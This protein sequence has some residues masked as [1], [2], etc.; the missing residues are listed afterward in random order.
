M[1]RDE[2]VDHINDMGLEDEEI[3]LFDGMENA[4]LGIAERFEDHGH[5]YFAVYSYKKMVT[6]LRGRFGRGMSREDAIDWLEFNTVGLYAGPGTPAI[7]RD[8]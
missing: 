4:F 7:L 1:T 3:I 5:V 6:S 2:I 8:F